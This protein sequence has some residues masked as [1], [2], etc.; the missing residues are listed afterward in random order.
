MTMDASIDTPLTTE[1]RHAALFAQMVMQL[2]S[3]A[4]VMLGQA[5]NPMTGK[6]ETDLETAQLLVEQLEMLEVKTKG[7]L[8]ADEQRLLKQSLMTLRMAFV[9]AVNA[10]K[11]PAAES[12]PE[13]TPVADAASDESKK[14]FSKSYGGA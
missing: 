5:P 14:K 9:E 2:A 3:T 11:Q 7:N 1:Q 4:L 12:Q 8:G 6:T 10:P 13:P